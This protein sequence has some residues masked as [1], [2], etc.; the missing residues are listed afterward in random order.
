M[1]TRLRAAP[2]PGGAPDS[3]SSPA[4]QSV[5][6]VSHR[7]YFGRKSRSKEL[8]PRGPRQAEPSEPKWSHFCHFREITHVVIKDCRVSINRQDNQCLVSASAPSR[9]A[10]GGPR[11]GLW[12]LKGGSEERNEDF[13]LFFLCFFFFSL[14]L[15]FFV[16]FFSPL[17][18]FCALSSS[19]WLGGGFGAAFLSVRPIPRAPPPGGAPPVLR[20]R[21]LP[22]LAGGRLLPTDGGLQPLPVPRSGAAAA[23]HEHPQRHPRAHAVRLASRGTPRGPGAGLEPLPFSPL[24]RE[25]FVFAKLRREEHEEGLYVIRWSVLDFNRMILSVVKRGHQQVR[26]ASRRLA[27]RC[28]ACPGEDSLRRGGKPASWKLAFC[29]LGRIGGSASGVSM[30]EGEGSSFEVEH[31]APAGIWQQRFCVLHIL[32]LNPCVFGSCIFFC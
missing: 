6:A 26:R 29:R 3:L 15:F 23:R 21:P 25:E 13:S 1:A 7:G 8:E 32:L 12:G 20:E 31:P 22:G 5:E 2:F 9:H 10:V 16:V 24:A 19:G 11:V 18:E 4:P 17:P 30:R 14:V 27:A 28:Q